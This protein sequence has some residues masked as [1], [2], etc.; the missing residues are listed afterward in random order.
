MVDEVKTVC[1]SCSYHSEA[2]CTCDG[3]CEVVPV[4]VHLAQVL[5]GTKVAKQVKVINNMLLL[6]TG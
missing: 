2:G 3:P 4:L 5:E 1:C 6:G